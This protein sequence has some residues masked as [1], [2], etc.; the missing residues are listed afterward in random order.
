M[1]SLLRSS[2]ERQQGPLSLLRCAESV[3]ASDAPPLEPT[4]GES[5]LEVSRDEGATNPVT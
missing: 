3:I 2:T 1:V 4:E 5:C